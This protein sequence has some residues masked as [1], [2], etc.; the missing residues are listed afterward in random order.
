MSKLLL[1]SDLHLGHKNIIK[2]REGFDSL[3]HHN[4]TLFENLASSVNKRDSIIFLGDIAFDKAWLER[5]AS[6]K[7][8]KKMLILGN[9]DLEH[10]IKMEDL[11]ATYDRIESLY[12]KRN[13]YFTHCPIHP[14]QFRGKTHNIH[15]HLHGKL[16]LDDRYINVCVEHTNWKPIEFAIAIGETNG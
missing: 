3:E 7:C 9:H 16:I 8:T 12:S 2:F 1:T 14:S 5:I 15:G 11:L 13:K 10:G 4:E 6:I